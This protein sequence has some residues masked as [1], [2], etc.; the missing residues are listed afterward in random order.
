MD[1]SPIKVW[2]LLV[3]VFHWSLVTSV[4][5][6]WF[7]ADDFRSAHEW[8]GYCALALIAIRFVWGFVGSR[9]AHFAQFVRAPAA[10]L[11]YARQVADGHAPRYTGHNPLGGWMVLALMF[12]VTAIGTT[13]WMLTLDAFFGESW[14]ESMHEA[15]AIGLLWLAAIHVAGAVITGWRHG[16]NLVRAMVSGKKRASGPADID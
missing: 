4:A 3:R 1:H 16:E 8:V 5:V 15:L 12:T 10:V 13:G 7:T 14:L 6:S 2:D 9:Y 11:R